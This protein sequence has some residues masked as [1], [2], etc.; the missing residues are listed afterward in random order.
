MSDETKKIKVCCE[1]TVIGD[2]TSRLSSL[3]RNLARQMT[4]REWWDAVAA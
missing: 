4:M 1:T 3:I 2:M